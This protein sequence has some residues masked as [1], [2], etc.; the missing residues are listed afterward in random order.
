MKKIFFV[1]TLLFSFF[2]LATAED[3]KAPDINVPS[4][5]LNNLRFTNRARCALDSKKPT[6]SVFLLVQ[7][8][9][10]AKGIYRMAKVTGNDSTELTKM[11][12]QVYRYAVVNLIKL[13]HQKLMNGQLPLL[14]VDTTQEF[15]PE[16][17][18]KISSL[19]KSDEYCNDLDIYLEN[20]WNISRSTG[21]SLDI[22]SNLQAF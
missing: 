8:M 4:F 14:P 3:W 5:E 15:V 13:I 11:G 16:G 6:E 9:E 18:A 20:L 22:K 12:I 17:Y 7:N 1:L 21:D 19:C 10:V 2:N